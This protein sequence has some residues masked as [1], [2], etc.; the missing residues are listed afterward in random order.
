LEQAQLAVLDGLKNL[1]NGTTPLKVEPPEPGE[2]QIELLE[3]IIGAYDKA[4]AVR[5]NI[6]NENPPTLGRHNEA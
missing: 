2:L 4:G 6:V 3:K 1:L 5:V